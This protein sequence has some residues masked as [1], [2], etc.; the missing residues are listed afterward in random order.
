M[1]YAT[2]FERSTSDYL[3]TI[4]RQRT[5]GTDIL[6]SGF[7]PC[8]CVFPNFLF[9]FCSGPIPKEL[10]ALSALQMLSLSRNQLTGEESEK[11]RFSFRAEQM[12]TDANA[13]VGQDLRR[14]DH[15]NSRFLAI[16]SNDDTFCF[17]SNINRAHST[18]ARRSKRL[19]EPQSQLERVR[20]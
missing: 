5:G 8:I 20:W 17:H 3:G 11:Y 16:V 7:T 10:G 4:S 6:E 19:G 1:Q 14:F 2:L 12:C 18:A 15:I 9:L 13:L